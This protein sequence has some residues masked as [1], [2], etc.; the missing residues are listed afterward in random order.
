MIIENR[1]TIS[2]KAT[3]SGIKMQ[4]LSTKSFEPLGKLFPVGVIVVEKQKDKVVYVNERAVE[5]FGFD[6]TGL[7]FRE[8]ALNMAKMQRLDNEGYSYE[9]LPLIKALNGEETH[10]QEVIFQRADQTELTISI[11]SAPLSDARGEVT[12]A[13]SVFEDITECKKAQEALRENNRRITDVLASIDDYVYAIDK[14]WNFI[15]VNNKSANDWD[16][17]PE[18]LIGKNY[19]ETFPLFLGTEVET[20]YREA[21]AKKEIRRFE[22]KTIYTSGCKEFT[23][24][25][26]VEGI[27]VYGKDITERKLLQQKLEDYSKNLEG[28]VEE[29]TKQLEDATRLAT[30]GQVAGMVG[31][32][33][34]NPLQTIVN[35]LYCAKQELD[36][37]SDNGIKQ[38]T[39]ETLA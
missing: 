5:L 29:R 30:I 20:N 3:K 18:E 19:W 28:L 9:Q 2:L 39:L 1:A 32:D 4:T 15:Y 11:H 10:N 12:G 33:I 31:H 21:M 34:R 16:F 6:P 23:V 35:E 14:N 13:L 8:Y 7:A 36:A 25:P 38:G 22:W 17:K 27:T 24:F 37:A 26:S